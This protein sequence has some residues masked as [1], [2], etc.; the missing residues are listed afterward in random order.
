M[1]VSASGAKGED[2]SLMSKLE[3]EPRQRWFAFLEASGF[4]CDS[5]FDTEF[6][7]AVV[8][9]LREIFY[10]IAQSERV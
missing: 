1:G 2:N 4:R 7:H 3:C 5:A 10:P 6:L 8:Y 9:F